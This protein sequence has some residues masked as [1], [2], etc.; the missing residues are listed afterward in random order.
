MKSLRLFY[1]VAFFLVSI[2][3]N[4]T[5][6]QWKEQPL[7]IGKTFT[8][9]S[10]ILNEERQLNV[11]LPYDYNAND[12][13]RYNVVFV[14]DGALEEDFLPVAGIMQN[15]MQPWVN[16]ASPSIVVGIGNNTRRRDFTFPVNNLDFVEKEGFSKSAFKVYGGS[17]KYIS[18]IENELIPFIDQQF[19][20]SAIRTV[21]GE[22]LA[23]LFVTELLLKHSHLFHQYVIISP[24]LWW[25][26]YDLLLNAKKYSLALIKEK[27]NVFVALPNRDEELNMY[28]AGQ[29]LYQLL[30]NKSIYP[31]LNVGFLHLSSETHATV[32]HRAV[33][34]AIIYF[35]QFR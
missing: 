24:S 10:A 16:K 12:T 30:A 21:I 28:E 4:P 3:L 33:Y 35:N 31:N 29:K 17:E 15:S 5:Y 32:L 9:Q 25:G 11:F 18:F 20:T 26:E 7:S 14:L 6:A 19:K 34:E 13:I 27:K 23:G 1:T 2:Q 8:F 22:S